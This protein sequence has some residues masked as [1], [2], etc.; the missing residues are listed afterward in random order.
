MTT[1]VTDGVWVSST[2]SDDFAP[3]PE[4]GGTVHV[5]RE[6]DDVQAGI[7]HAPDDIGDPEVF[8]FPHD[9]TILVLEGEVQITIEDGPTLH[10]KPGSIAS[11]R[12][13]VRST[14]R[15]TPG[16]KEFWIYS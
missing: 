15:P 6:D 7:W 8:E 16:F 4:V 14:W 1:Q 10:L 12:K 5:L 2:D 13:G 11:F 3:D 9:E